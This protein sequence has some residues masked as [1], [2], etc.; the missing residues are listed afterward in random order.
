MLIYLPVS[1][2]HV[3]ICLAGS[4]KQN[5]SSSMRKSISVGIVFE[6][7]VRKVHVPATTELEVCTVSA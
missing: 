7:V 5:G 4:M 2:V 3:Y 6:F 1:D